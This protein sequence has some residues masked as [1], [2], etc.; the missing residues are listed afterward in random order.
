MVADGPGGGGGGVSGSVSSSTPSWSLS[1][2]FCPV[3][4]SVTSSCDL[5]SACTSKRI[6]QQSLLVE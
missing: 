1:S 6:N 2:V 4:P 5:F 3:L